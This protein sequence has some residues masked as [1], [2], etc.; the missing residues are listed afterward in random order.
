[1]FTFSLVSAAPENAMFEKDSRIKCLT[2]L[3]LY[4][5]PEKTV[6]EFIG[7]SQHGQLEQRTP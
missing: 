6:Q 7:V 4:T 5:R 1:V 2:R 3:H